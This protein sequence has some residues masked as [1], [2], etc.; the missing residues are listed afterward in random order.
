M[1]YSII[2]LAFL[3][4]CY[5]L[6]QLSNEQLFTNPHI[7]HKKT[8][9]IYSVQADGY[10]KAEHM[11]DQLMNR[12]ILIFEILYPKCISVFCFDQLT[13]HNAIAEDTL[14]T[15]RINLSFGRD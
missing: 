13:N 5:G 4:L 1:E 15:M 12:A 10:W 8:F 3:C 11:L 2:V 9:V 7:E 6:L 14:I